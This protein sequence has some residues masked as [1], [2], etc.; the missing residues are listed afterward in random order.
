MLEETLASV[1]VVAACPAVV[2][3]FRIAV[4]AAAAGDTFAEIVEAVVAVY[5]RVAPRAVAAA[6]RIA[7]AAVKVA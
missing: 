7:V 3:W 4:V 5:I 1:V 6:Q 2:A